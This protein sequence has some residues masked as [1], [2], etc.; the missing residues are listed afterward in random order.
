MI[1]EVITT[2]Q[3]DADLRSIYEY[4]ALELLSPDNAAGMLTVSLKGIQ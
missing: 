3:A 1:Y 4:I 2:D